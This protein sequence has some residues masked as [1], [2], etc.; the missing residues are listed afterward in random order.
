IGDIAA[1]ADGHGDLLPG[2]AQVAMQE[3]THTARN[4][5]R[6]LQHEPTRPFHYKDKG[7][8]ATIG[9]NRAV[10]DIGWVHLSGFPAWAIWA[11]V[12]IATLIGR[13]NRFTVM[14]QW[15]WSYLTHGRGAR[16]ITEQPEVTKGPAAAT[17]TEVRP[18]L[19]GAP[20]L[21]SRVS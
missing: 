20:S 9:R 4:I 14:L 2:V 13:R 17:T 7:M 8:L 3:G 11:V 16:I 5:L 1:V 15:M 10:A 6:R 19:P 21:R 18:Q 12:H